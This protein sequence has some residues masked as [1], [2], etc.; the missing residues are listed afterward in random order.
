MD[1]FGLP[2]HI[3]AQ[4]LRNVAHFSASNPLVP[5]DDAPVLE[6]L[7]AETPFSISD[8][9]RKV[10]VNGFAFTGPPRWTRL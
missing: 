8:G 2:S 5:N 1:S 10:V 9:P 3:L 4:P 6:L 7:G